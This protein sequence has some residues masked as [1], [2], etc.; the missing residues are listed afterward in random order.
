MDLLT[1]RLRL[2]L[3]TPDDAEEMAVVLADESLY[4][5]TGGEPPTAAALRSQYAIWAVSGAQPVPGRRFDRTWV[6]RQLAGGEAVGFAQVSVTAD[7]S[8]AVLAW[9][10]GVRWQGRGLA[11][12]AAERLARL[13]RDEGV[14][15]L[16]ASIAAGHLGSE[17]IAAGL[18]MAVTDRLAGEE[19]VWEAATP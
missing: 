12:E 7:R 15:V 3:V 11:R 14:V 19:R 8:V 5:W 1:T 13:A 4:A 10:V 16:R 6:L 2:R 17:R 18:G 9:V